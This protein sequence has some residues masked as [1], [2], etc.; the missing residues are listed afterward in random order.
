M[1]QGIFLTQKE[2]SSM[3]EDVASKAVSKYANSL[4]TAQKAAE[5]RGSKRSFIRGYDELCD[6][7]GISKSTAVKL[8]KSKAI[9]FIQRGR[10]LFFNPD[11]VMKALGK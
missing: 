5:D 3:M 9:P 7:L 1:E 10:I 2:L 4:P 8:K 6:F 11:D